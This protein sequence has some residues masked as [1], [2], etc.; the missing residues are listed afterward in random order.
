MMDADRLSALLLA[1]SL[2]IGFVYYTT[3]EITLLYAAAAVLMV[4]FAVAIGS[5]RTRD[6]GDLS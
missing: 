3:G 6:D 2:T 1:V 5:V 4:A